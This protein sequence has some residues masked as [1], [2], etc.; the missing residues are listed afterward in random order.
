M[1]TT[2]DIPDESLDALLRLSGAKTKREAILTAVE[3]YN[4]RREIERL[5]ATFGTWKMDSNEEI[6]AAD[7]VEAAK[8]R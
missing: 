3:E 6:E 7:L 8:S 4:R 1:K 2:I 5:V